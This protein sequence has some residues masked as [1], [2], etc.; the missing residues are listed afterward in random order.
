MRDHARIDRTVWHRHD[1]LI[2]LPLVVQRGGAREPRVLAG[3]AFHREL[4]AR[5]LRQCIPGGIDLAQVRAPQQAAER[6]RVVMLDVGVKQAERREQPGRG[7][8][9]D[10]L[11]AEHRRHAGREQ[12]AVA[13]EG[14]QGELARIA[15]ALGR[16]RLDGADHVRGGDQV[17]AVGGAFERHAERPGDLLLERRARLPGIELQRAANEVRRVDVAEQHVRV[18]DG[19]RLAAHVVADR[20]GRSARALGPRLQRT[21][22]IDPDMRAAAGADFGEI[23][24]RHFQ[25]VARAGEQPRADHDPG[26]DRVFVR[27]RDLPVLD[28]RGLRGGA[29]HV[30]GD[31]LVEVLGAREC[32]R[33]DHAAGRPRTR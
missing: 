6:A 29:A 31:D 32:M 10:A 24:R 22:R 17:R 7:R 18:G 19:R 26:A 5:L 11:D 4:L 13:A 21:A 28:H 25:R 14:E 9:H 2:A 12:R 20:S 27:A 33:A 30:E 8:H 15:P 23:D 16:H 3:E 1:Q